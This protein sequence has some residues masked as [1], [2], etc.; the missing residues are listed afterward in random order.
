MVHVHEFRLNFVHVGTGLRPVRAGR[1]PASTRA[2][3]ELGGAADGAVVRPGFLQPLR[4]QFLLAEAHQAVKQLVAAADHVQ[5][6]F[7]LMFLEDPVQAIFQFRHQAL[8]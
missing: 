3:V 4:L 6:A 2:E 8:P 7:P 1:R 5:T